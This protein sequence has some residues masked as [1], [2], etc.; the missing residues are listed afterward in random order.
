MIMTFKILNISIIG[1]AVL[2][3]RGLNV[4]FVVFLKSGLY[5]Y[6]SNQCLYCS[7]GHR[8]IIQYT[9]NKNG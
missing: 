7:L 4:H 8:Y 6:S 3:S 5:F 9:L 1:L 2:D